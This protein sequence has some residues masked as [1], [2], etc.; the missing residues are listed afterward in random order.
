MKKKKAKKHARAPK[1]MH[2]PVGQMAVISAIIA[3]SLQGGL[4]H[5]P[6]LQAQLAEINL[7]DLPWLS[8]LEMCAV[9]LQEAPHP[10]LATEPSAPS[11]PE[12]CDTALIFAF[13]P[14][15]RYVFTN[16]TEATLGLMRQTLT[17]IAVPDTVTIGQIQDALSCMGAGMQ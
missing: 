1:K 16:M 13:T 11:S 14:E 8:D 9:S 4:T 5:A 2:W 6:V 12:P 17:Q 15:Q 7:C 3:V 10:P